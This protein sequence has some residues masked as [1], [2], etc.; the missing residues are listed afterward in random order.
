MSFIPSKQFIFSP[1]PRNP[2]RTDAYLGNWY[3][4]ARPLHQY[5][6]RGTT[7]TLPTYTSS[8][9]IDMITIEDIST[10]WNIA[11]QPVQFSYGIGV[12]QGQILE[13][14]PTTPLSYS[15]QSIVYT[16]TSISTTVELTWSSDTSTMIWQPISSTFISRNFFN[17]CIKCDHSDYRIGIP[18]KMLGKQNNGI[19]GQLPKDTSEGC[20]NCDPV[21]GPVGSKKGNVIS[22][23]GTATIRSA[24][25]NL[26]KTYYSNYSAYLKKRGKQYD[27][28]LH[29][30]PD[31]KYYDKTEPV[32]PYLPQVVQP[33]QSAPLT[34]NSSYYYGSNFPNSACNLVVF[35]PSNRP[36]ST[37][38]GVES[39]TYT[40]RAK[41]NAIQ[42]NN[43]S[44]YKTY[45]KSFTYSETPPFFIKNNTSTPKV[46]G[47]VG[48]KNCKA[49]PFNLA[50]EIGGI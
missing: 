2:A 37:Q 22:F 30:I 18:F 10:I 35:N 48:C 19:N 45:K 1:K 34:L 29:P 15:Y 23:S 32:S 36:F 49:S 42:T 39:S 43:A 8:N 40:E 44:F 24:T 50:L 6:L 41:Y 31:I 38:G 14:L 11:S 12:Y 16:L 9:T 26:S 5:R 17:P 3:P 13:V 7:S 33:P 46:F 28:S 47:N 20:L 25:T 21:K 4:T 27:K